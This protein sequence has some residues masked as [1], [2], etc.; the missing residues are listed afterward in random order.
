M[1]YQSENL[2]G[3]L[4]AFNAL[5]AFATRGNT[6]AD[7]AA[8]IAAPY[9]QAR[10]DMKAGAADILAQQ[11]ARQ[12]STLAIQKALPFVIAGAGVLILFSPKVIRKIKGRKI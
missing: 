2:S 5:K 10:S 9:E 7:A 4:E 12:N 11:E 8:A 3:L 6:E 1:T